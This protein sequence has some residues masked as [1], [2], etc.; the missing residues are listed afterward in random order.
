MSKKITKR[1]L[2][3]FLKQGKRRKAIAKYYGVS[4]RTIARYIHRYGLGGTARKGRPTRPKKPEAIRVKRFRRV[5]ASVPGYVRLLNEE[6]R[7]VNIQSPPFRFINQKTLV[8]SN[9]PRNPRG[10]FSTVGMY[11][12]VYVSNVYFLYATRIRYSRTP[13]AFKEICE[14]TIANAESILEESYPHYYIVRIVAYTF[15][16]RRKKP[17]AIKYG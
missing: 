6:Y 16:K 5:W 17:K 15:S 9:Q 7:L 4:V 1:E 14:W 2:K 8:C 13:V 12:I 10:K 11:F 3:K